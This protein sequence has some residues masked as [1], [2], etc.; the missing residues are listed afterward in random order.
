MSIRS[1]EDSKLLDTLILKTHHSVEPVTIEFPTRHQAY[2][3][4]QRI[5]RYKTAVITG[6]LEMPDGDLLTGL[7]NLSLSIHDNVL[8][9]TSEKKIQAMATLKTILEQDNAKEKK[10]T[11]N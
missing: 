6:A 7:E 10:Q 11:E 1:A 8:T 9:C 2:A 4:R 3:M 5:Y